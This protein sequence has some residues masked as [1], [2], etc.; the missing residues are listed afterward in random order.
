MSG[1]TCGSS[2]TAGTA[3]LE[4]V[5]HHTTKGGAHV[6]R[7]RCVS[8]LDSNA[9][10][11]VPSLRVHIDLA[12]LFAQIGTEQA[13]AGAEAV[14][15]ERTL[16]RTGR[17]SRRQA[18]GSVARYALAP[19]TRRRAVVRIRGPA[20][21]VPAWSRRSRPRGGKADRGPRRPHRRRD[22]HRRRAGRGRAPRLGPAS[23]SGEQRRHLPEPAVRG[24]ER[25]RTGGRSSRSTSTPCST[26]CGP[27]YRTCRAAGWGR[28]VN[29]TSN[30]V[31]LVIP[32]FTHYIASKMAVIGLTRGLA[33]E[34]ADARHHRQRRSDPAW[35]RTGDAPR[36]DRPIVLRHRPAD[37]G[38]QAGPGARRPHRNHLVP[39]VRRRRVHHRAD[40]LRRRRA[41]P[42]LKGVPQW[43]LMRGSH[44]HLAPSA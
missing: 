33:T 30:S 43:P 27:S 1:A 4:A 7:C 31:N 29:M 2:T 15:S 37:A 32:G 44:E 42:V 34:L 20:R 12:P 3:V 36:P 5:L 28:I 13:P 26:R 21:T 25:P 39:R 41:G 17:A 38:D 10:G 19:R 23:D 18:G 40:L 6:P 22:R 11:L 16:R 9:D 8:L 35:S 24:D 14:T